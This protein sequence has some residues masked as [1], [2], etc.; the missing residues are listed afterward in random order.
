MDVAQTTPS[1]PPVTVT[2]R[3]GLVVGVKQETLL[4]IEIYQEPVRAQ[5]MCNAHLVFVIRPRSARENNVL[6]REQICLLTQSVLWID[7]VSHI[8]A[9]P[10]LLAI[11]VIK[12]L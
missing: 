11:I 6:M 12:L 3:L 2:P 10:I 9:L 5:M 8:A 4:E 1:A 7:N